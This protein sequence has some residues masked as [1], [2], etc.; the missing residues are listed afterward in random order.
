MCWQA[1]TVRETD[2]EDCFSGESVGS[3]VKT[4][5]LSF[6]LFGLLGLK[7]I[8]HAQSP[9]E[10]S[11]EGPTLSTKRLVVNGLS[12]KARVLGIDGKHFVAV[13]DL[14]QAMTG[15][16]SYTA[17][18]INLTLVLASQTNIQ[19]TQSG[20]TGSIKGT[21][22]YYFNRNY[23]NKPDTASEAWLIDGRL[24]TPA[25]Q[26]VFGT[27]RLFRVGNADF[28]ERIVKYS[29]ADGNG[30]FDLSGIPIGEY[31]LVLKSNHS[32]AIS[33]RDI[34]GKVRV[35]IVQVKPGEILDASLDFGVNG[36][37]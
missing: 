29:A 31:T 3:S 37:R 18:Q 9:K 4:C 12:I 14:A 8:G 10:K 13:E 26:F 20:G 25:D 34:S 6:V 28:S 35:R 21:L 32:K 11:V 16:V 30:N 36:S 33:E 24:D 15:T 5:V 7:S 19:A 23:G 2:S 27:R 1:A 17:D 22:T